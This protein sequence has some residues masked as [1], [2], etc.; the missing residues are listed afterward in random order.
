MKRIATLSAAI[1][2]GAS[3]SAWAEGPGEHFIENWD[4]N[5]DGIVSLEDLTEKRGDVFYM[6]DEDESGSLNASEYALFD[7]TRAADMANN[8]GSHAEQAMRPAQAGMQ[9]E[10]N[11]TDG[12]GEVS[13]EEFLSH[14]AAWLELMDR[15]TD[16]VITTA[17]FGPGKGG[18]GKGQGKGQG[19]GQGQA[20]NG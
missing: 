9:L 5:E 14:T 10:F 3:A 15:N 16:G 1:I 11:D 17:D 19:G 12:N 8:A 4:M 7:E 2:L 20:K 6:F 18:M 13:L